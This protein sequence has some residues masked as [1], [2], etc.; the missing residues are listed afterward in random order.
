MLH[1]WSNSSTIQLIRLL[2]PVALLCVAAY[3]HQAIMA[4]AGTQTVTIHYASPGARPPVF[5]AGSFTAPPWQ[6]IELD[7]KVSEQDF[8]FSRDF[9]IAEGQ[10]QYKF[11]LGFGDWWVCDENAEIGKLIP[12]KSHGSSR[13]HG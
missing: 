5:V 8:E 6:P 9:D 4:T 3:E 10:W 11:R 2:L 13:V 7:Y 1:S 12:W